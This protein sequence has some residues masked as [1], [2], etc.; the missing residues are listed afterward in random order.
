MFNLPS[1]AQCVKLAILR[2]A[3]HIQLHN[4]CEVGESQ[5]LSVLRIARHFQLATCEDTMRAGINTF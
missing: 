1:W 5:L 2:I 4:F 3:R